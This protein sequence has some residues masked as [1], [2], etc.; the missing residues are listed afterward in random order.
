MN[1]TITKQ[2]A[3][4]PFLDLKNT[5]KHCIYEIDESGWIIY[6][7]ENE[8]LIVFQKDLDKLA[9][10]LDNFK[11][12]PVTKAMAYYKKSAELTA[13][14]FHLNIK[15]QAYLFVYPKTKP[16]AYLPV[17]TFKT[18]QAEDLDI[19]AAHYSLL[20]RKELEQYI[21]NK[22]L[23]MAYFYDDIIGFGGFHSEMSMGLLEVLPPFRNQGFGQ[24]IE[25]FLIN[26]AL[27]KGLIPY[28]DILINNKASVKL[29][30]N[31][32]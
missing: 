8:I 13:E 27:D 21:E 6:E 5:Y 25:S 23:Y 4:A 11:N 3:A 24:E 31:L 30:K 9:V 18:A 7:Q 19:I 14:T 32:A 26:K 2:L 15:D 28:S 10:W 17:L 29:Q 22:Q 16:I 12:Y 20:E 1:E